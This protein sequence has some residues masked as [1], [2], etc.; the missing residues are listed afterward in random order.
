MSRRDLEALIATDTAQP[1]NA[2][3]EALAR[4]LARRG[5]SVAVVFY[6]SG[7]WGPAGVDTVYDF[8]VLVKRFRD[9]SPELL[10]RCGGNVLPPN[11]YYL[12]LKAGDVTL[13]AKCAVMRLKQFE[14]AAR[15]R[16]FTPHIWARFS[17]P[18]RLLQ[19]KEEAVR[20][21]LIGAIANAVVEFHR[22]TL[23]LVGAVP[24]VDFWVEG[25][26]STYASE[27][28]SEKPGRARRLVE[29]SR[30]AFAE[31]TR[32]ALPLCG[33]DARLTPEGVVESR[34]PE[35]RKRRFRWAL[36]VKRPFQ[37][38]VVVG[39]LIKAACT[40]QGGLDYARWK[41]ERH[42]GVVIPLSDFQRRH[43]LLAGGLL[44]LKVLWRGGLR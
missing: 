16:S 11:V 40:F 35:A 37:K 38:G 29:A 6:G 17:Q 43:P 5:E 12:E 14:A 18:C 32:L 25:L 3:V 30:A 22:Q 13:R 44:F 42:S 39:R 8:Y 28:R 4:E 9:W 10:L 41:V 24:I 21:A 33:M 7:L 36:K 2:D 27:I 26:R 15:G 20:T 23:P 31:R 34:I 19:I 1:V